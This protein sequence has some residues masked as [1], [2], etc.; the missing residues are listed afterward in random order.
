MMM[1][2]VPK[3]GVAESQNHLF[4][5]VHNSVEWACFGACFSV[6]VG[7]GLGIQNCDP[8]LALDAG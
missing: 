1:M 5:C 8:Y 2:D 7:F 6:K 4:R 3:I